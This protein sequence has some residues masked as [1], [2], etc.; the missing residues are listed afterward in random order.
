M[1]RTVAQRKAG[2]AFTRGLVERY[3][4]A[5]TA[6]GFLALLAAFIATVLLPGYRLADRLSQSTAALKLVSE[7]RSKPETIESTLAG[8]RDRLRSGGYVGDSVAELARLKREYDS[9]IAQLRETR[10]AGSTELQPAE[11]AWAGYRALLEPV[12]V[13]NGIPYRDTDRAGT[14]LNA[15]GERLMADTLEALA[16][17]RQNAAGMA[18][19]LAGIGARLEGEAVTGAATLRRLMIIGMLFAGVLLALVARFQWLKAREERAARD[20]RQQTSDILGTVKEGLCLLDK[21]FR[22]GKT[23]SAALAAIF[24][25]DSFEGLAFDDLLRD[26]VSEATLETASKYVKL[27]WGD[28]ANENLIKSINPLAEVEVTFDHGNSGRDTRYLEF[29]FHRV[30]Q[31]GVV[32]QVLVSVSDVTSRVLLSREI[33]QSQDSADAQMD[34]LLAMLQVEPGQLETFMSDCNA[35]LRMVNSVLKVPARTD[36]DFRRKVDS[37]FREMHKIKGDAATLGV[38]T[39]E[40]RAHAFEDMLKDLRE[41]DELSG[42]DFL[43]LVVRLDDL[44]AHLRA[45]QELVGRLDNLRA[46]SVLAAPSPEVAPAPHSSP[47]TPNPARRLS[48]TLETLAARVAANHGKKVMLV[49]TGLDQV[50]MDYRR[51][52]QNLVIQFVRNAVV[53]GI[54]AASARDAAGKNPAGLLQVEFKPREHGYEL[55]FQDDGAGIRADLVKEKAIALGLVDPARAATMDERSTLG[56]IF[57]AGISTHD[58]DDRDA[59][60][61]VGLDIV[62]KSL[63]E[64]GGRIAV[65][66][67]PGRLT[68]FRVLLPG[69]EERQDAVA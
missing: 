33:K 26:V 19:N 55:M 24:R 28:R 39:V 59:G 65:A 63:Q 43:P 21:D 6:V 15:N 52:V 36:A 18:D 4:G 53:H 5:V 41:R 50:P 3:K 22:I 27:L 68:R 20:A 37:L 38:P 34:L 47:V 30:R 32:R 13:F 56:L 66:T 57:K 40:S 7:H 17:G 69:P 61:G 44:F 42:N 9:A 67:V 48:D 62:W 29:D 23:H 64:M 54:E 16:Y 10:V 31:D 11:K 8:I 14:Q 51:V 1:N 58:G 2:P 60:R 25:R 35:S 45:I 49:T 46:A 12:A